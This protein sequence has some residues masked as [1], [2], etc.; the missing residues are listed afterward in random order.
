MKLIDNWHLSWKLLSV[1]LSAVGASV[2][3]GY[4]ALPQEFK[5]AIPPEW[6]QYAALATFVAGILGRV[7]AQP[8]VLPE[9]PDEEAK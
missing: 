1:Q 8:N 2:T 5:S 9:K 6:V 3:A 4:L 7:I